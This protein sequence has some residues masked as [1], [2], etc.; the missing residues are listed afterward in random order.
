MIVAANFFGSL[1]STLSSSDFQQNLIHF[2][3]ALP[4]RPKSAKLDKWPLIVKGDFHFHLRC[5]VVCHSYKSRDPLRQL[6][7]K[8]TRRLT[9]FLTECTRDFFS[10]PSF[11][12]VEMWRTFICIHYEAKLF[13]TFTE[14]K[15]CR[16]KWF[17]DFEISL[18]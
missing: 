11:N 3:V 7:I 8:T 5:F 6:E 10:L 18:F 2:V 16:P 17:Q 14:R 13:D 15:K 9:Y 12:L 4:V 1:K